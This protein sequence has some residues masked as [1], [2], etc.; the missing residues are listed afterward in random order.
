MG[1]MTGTDRGR[2]AI[3]GVTLLAATLPLAACGGGGGG[4]VQSTP[5][6]PQVVPVPTPPPP[7]PPPPP[8]PPASTALSYSPVEYDASNGASS[9]NAAAA[10]K[11]GF[12]GSGITVGVVDSGIDRD[13][14]EF[15]GRI[16]PLS[17]DFAGNPDIEDEDG[18]GTEVSGVIAAAANGRNTLGVAWGSTILALRTDRPGSCATTGDDGGCKHPDTAI[19][20]AIDFARQSGAKVINISLGGGEAGQPVVDAVN[21]ATAADII[22]VIS[23]GN[24]G[25]EPEGANPD[26]FAQV[27]GDPV[28]H[29]L[30]IIAGSLGQDDGTGTRT[31]DGNVLSSFS[32]RAGSFGSTYLAALG[33]RVR[34]VNNMNQAVVASGTSFAAPV[35]SGAVALIR[36]AFPNLTGKQVVDLIYRTARDLGATGIDSVYGRGALDLTRAF[37]PQGAL[38]LAGSGVVLGSLDGGQLGSAM[39]DGD[40]ARGVAATALDVYGRAFSAQVAGGARPGSVSAPLAASLRGGQRTAGVRTSGGLIALSVAGAGDAL[41]LDL[42]RSDAVAARATAL[43][44][45]QR[46]DRRTSVRLGLAR[47]AD[48]LAERLDG[49]REGAFLVAGRADRQ[50]GLLTRPAAAVALTH[51]IGPLRLTVAAEN[52]QSLSQSRS[53]LPSHRTDWDRSGYSALS[54]VAETRVGAAAFA[55]GATRMSERSAMLGAHLGSAL[56]AGRGADSW[57][58]DA[59][60]A[61]DLGAGVQVGA[62][63]RQGFTAPRTG[64]LL[65]GGTL[66]SNAWSLDLAKGGVLGDDQLSL[67]LSQPL[68]VAGG[69]LNLTVP[70]SYDY[71][72]LTSV[73]VQQRLDLSPV[74]AERTAEIAYGRSIWGG[75]LSMNGWWRIDPGNNARVVN[76][77]GALVRWSAI[78]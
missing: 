61:A 49:S 22:I 27:A 34:T 77:Q 64:G 42:T 52:G 43:A 25:E 24:D 16:S 33:Y 28:S 17:R 51:E 6:P 18:H 4:G 3:V 23:A 75:R 56:G 12:N 60:T 38:K 15:T 44:F 30:V 70:T 45:V 50:S 40:R 76:E 78:F 35:I 66:R 2:S 26:P 69:G 1:A 67:R 47:G 21:R 72:S 63:W 9:I 7:P 36:Q 58:L 37:Q 5:V 74:G 14:V 73:Y 46:L 68:R 57:F 54:A 55:L 31:T 62:K 39:G 8:T 29:G 53:L 10:Y 19:G 48:G 71:A 13:Q 32:N 65:T 41:P 11:A 59:G 20:A